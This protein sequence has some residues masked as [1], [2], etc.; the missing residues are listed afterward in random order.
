M[1]KKI[2]I[3]SISLL[4]IT[5][6]IYYFYNSRNKTPVF[7][8]RLAS[9]EKGDLNVIV[10]ATGNLSADTSVDVGTQ[11][12]G[13]L[14]KRYVDFNSKVKKGQLIAL[15]DTTILYATAKD[16][17]AAKQK[18]Q[19]LLNQYKRE[20]NRTKKLFNNTVLPQADY[21]QAITNYET[22][23]STFNSAEAQLYKAEVNLRYAKIKAPIN[24]VVI[25]RNIDEGQTVIASFNTPTL[26][27]I[28]NNLS[29]MHVQANVGE[30]DI[31][32]VK[33]GQNVNFTVDAYPDDVFT[34]IVQQVRLQPVTLQ[35]VV[36]YVVVVNVSNP[37]MKLIPG[38]TANV[39]ILVQELKDVLKVPSNAISFIPPKEYLEEPG[40]PL[41][42]SVKQQ[43]EQK[44]I[45]GN[46][47]I[48][49]KDVDP[50]IVYVWVKNNN[51]IFPKRVKKGFSDG[52]Y[53]EIVGDIKKGEQVVTG[54]N[55]S[56]ASNSNQKPTGTQNPFMPK[57]PTQKKNKQ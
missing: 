44:I 22:A 42:D 3:I 1:K 49:R 48:I 43:W 19:L 15:V 4:L 56:K 14:I 10:T 16:A 38:L 20:F 5:A 9:V 40:T 32:Q 31:G 17:K 53:T 11:V 23:Q 13:I 24:G 29:E 54:L 50:T 45:Q 55:K 27:T 57:F 39:N 52:V 6:G 21:D 41:P 7:F 51:A 12:T 34:G 2:I 18:A 47:K 26:F 37:E 36:N 30:A 25:A 35:N 8:W 46:Q 28:A 33:V